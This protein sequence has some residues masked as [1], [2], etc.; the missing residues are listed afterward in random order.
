MTRPQIRNHGYPASCV[1]CWSGVVRIGYDRRGRQ[2][3]RCTGCR[4]SFGNSYFLYK[5]RHIYKPEK[6][7][8]AVALFRE[9]YSIRHVAGMVGLSNRT[10]QTYRNLFVPNGSVL[11]ACGRDAKHRGWCSW[12]FGQSERRQSWLARVRVVRL[13]KPRILRSELVYPYLLDTQVEGADLLLAVNAAVPKS[14]PQD[15]RAD[16]CQ[17]LILACL[18]GEVDA[19]QIAA[20]A[21][22][23]IKQHYKRYPRR[24]GIVSLDAPI[25]G[26]GT[27]TLA[28]VLEG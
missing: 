22:H 20:H 25:F 17:E 24:F 1:A 8:A 26:D 11:C 3:F 9:G 6:A 23:F 5:S 28:E 19:R 21:P 18:A 2:R 16:V 15:V 7:S 10:A 12:R 4:R 27:K 14:L 13:P